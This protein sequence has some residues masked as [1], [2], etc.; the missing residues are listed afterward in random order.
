LREPERVEQALAEEL[1]PLVAHPF[2]PRRRG[3]GH[4]ADLLARTWPRPAPGSAS[5][6]AARACLLRSTPSRAPRRSAPRPDKP[7]GSAACAPES[8]VVRTT[9][10]NNPCM[11]SESTVA[12]QIP[13][14]C[15]VI[16]DRRPEPVV[17]ERFKG[18]VPW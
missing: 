16:G 11:E 3:R 5:N 1:L 14:P 2:D 18:W 17:E 12:A 7:V 9:S 8:L 15:G 6:R 13:K 4:E 10:A